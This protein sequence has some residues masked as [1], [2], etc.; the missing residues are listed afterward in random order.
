MSFRTRWRFILPTVMVLCFIGTL[1]YLEIRDRTIRTE[2]LKQSGAR[3]D[4]AIVFF[5]PES[6]FVSDG[7]VDAQFIGLIPMFAIT[8]D[9]FSLSE[10]WWIYAAD[11]MSVWC[12]WFMIGFLID[13][14]KR[15]TSAQA[16][17]IGFGSGS[18][19]S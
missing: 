8:G 16:M 12:T 2:R 13:V 4:R 3:D 15:R 6:D 9:P 17:H 19:D 11:V 10:R 5:L 18:G 14:W 7:L 1:G